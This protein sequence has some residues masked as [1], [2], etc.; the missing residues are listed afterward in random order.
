MHTYNAEWTQFHRNFREVQS[1]NS[2]FMNLG[3][4]L[5]SR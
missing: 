5:F 1:T 3:T 4:Y 2:D